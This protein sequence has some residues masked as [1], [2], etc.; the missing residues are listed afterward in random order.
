MNKSRR[1]KDGILNGLTWLSTAVAVAVLL[2]VFIFMVRRGWSDLSWDLISTDYWPQNLNVAFRQSEAGEYSAPADLAA[3]DSFS[4]RYG[5]ALRDATDAQ[6]ATTLLITY[7]D[8]DSPLESAYVTTAGSQQGL[9]QAIHEDASV[10][11]LYYQDAAG[12]Q[13]I[14]GLLAG[15]DAASLVQKLDSEAVSIQSMYYQT[16][17]GGIRG[18]ILATLLLIGLTL[19]I[20]LPV[21]ILAAVYLNEVASRNRLTAML[22]QA[23]ETLN[24]VP[25]IIFGLSGVV[26]LFPVTQLFGASG[27]SI[28]LGALTMAVILLPVVIRQ[29]E[30]ALIVVPQSLRMG[31]LALGATR[32][33]TI[34]KV[35]LPNALPGILT[36]TL[37]SVSRVIGESAALIYTMSTVVTDNPKILQP[38]T[39]LA[40]QIWQI[41]SSEQ[42]D[43]KLASAVSLIILFMV[44]LLNLTV[45]LIT[46][47][48]S[49]R[50]A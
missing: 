25:S 31:S 15:D 19:L 20:V 48:L 42:P 5:F 27:Q 38:A 21:G 22:R 46:R 2:L 17:G 9:N 26:M 13:V 12:N 8:P 34:F 37:L 4:T 1:I 11:M 10:Q 43:F 24:G 18:S 16:A 32:S 39:S 41:M 45:K 44:L 23:I 47:R 14:A 7:V 30:E 49:R 6:N 50:W 33:Q 36:A 28:L 29:T 35:V 40:V 3:G